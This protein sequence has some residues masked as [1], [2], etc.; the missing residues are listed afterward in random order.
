MEIDLFFSTG[1]R[2]PKIDLAVLLT[3]TKSIF[4]KAN[5]RSLCTLWR[6]LSKIKLTTGKWTILFFFL[7]KLYFLFS[8]F[9]PLFLFF[10]CVSEKCNGNSADILVAQ[11]LKEM[12]GGKSGNRKMSSDWSA[13][14][15]GIVS[16]VQNLELQ[17]VRAI[18]HR[19]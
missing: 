5:A 17:A 11:P 15:V 6:P 9:H 10:S 16:L 19:L 12:E 2:V 3:K 7:C 18:N 1:C 13:A 4:S 8:G 14:A